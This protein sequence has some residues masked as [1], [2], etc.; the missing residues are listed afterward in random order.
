LGLPEPNLPTAARDRCQAAS[1]L[2]P[3]ASRLQKTLELRRVEVEAP[4]LHWRRRL[5]P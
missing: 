2:N 4:R 1:L 3:P 5:R